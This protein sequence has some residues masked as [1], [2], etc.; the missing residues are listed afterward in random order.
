MPQGFK[1][2][3]NATIAV[4]DFVPLT[5]PD[6][7]EPPREPPPA[8][9]CLACDSDIS[10]DG[11]VKHKEG[12]KPEAR[13]F[14]AQ[15]VAFYRQAGDA[16]CDSYRIQ[17]GS[18]TTITMG[19][20]EMLTPSFA[21]NEVVLKILD[22]AIAEGTKGVVLTV[23]LLSAAML[24]IHEDGAPPSLADLRRLEIESFWNLAYACVAGGG[25]IPDRAGITRRRRK[26][27]AEPDA[28]EDLLAAQQQPRRGDKDAVDG[29]DARVDEDV[30]MVDAD[31]AGV[32]VG[33][34]SSELANDLG[35]SVLQQS[36]DD[37]GVSFLQQNQ[38]AGLVR[39]RSLFK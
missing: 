29:G 8:S 6:G 3:Q 11:T 38:D 35:L 13:K 2:L 7:A 25:K 5:V 20:A 24:A 22:R 32:D 27:K 4:P 12:C 34:L 39:F 30:E 31:K 36:E 17:P 37:D 18:I 19:L 33:D 15:V 16:D 1:P 26:P 9:R 14:M 10:A 21:E 23:L 28:Y